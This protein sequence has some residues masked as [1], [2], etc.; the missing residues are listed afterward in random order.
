MLFSQTYNLNKFLETRGGC[1]FGN[2]P[3]ML[4]NFGLTM[5]LC[6]KFSFQTLTVKGDQCTTD[7][8]TPS[9]LTNLEAMPSSIIYN[10]PGI[11]LY[12]KLVLQLCFIIHFALSF[13]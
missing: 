13:Y 12:S 7:Q 5:Y 4:T 1:H 8:A 11:L 6:Q 10:Q 2:I 9:L 3:P